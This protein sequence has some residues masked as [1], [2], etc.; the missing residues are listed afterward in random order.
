MRS[1]LMVAALLFASA[2]QAQSVGLGQAYQSQGAQGNGTQGKGQGAGIVRAKAAQVQ[3][4]SLV[5]TVH[6]AA[7]LV[8]GLF[9]WPLC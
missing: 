4:R 7:Q 3:V 8:V 1:L 5:A 9:N 6:K 2:V